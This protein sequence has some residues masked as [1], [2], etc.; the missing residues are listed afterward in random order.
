M[1]SEGLRTSHV[2]FGEVRKT[3]LN[4]DPSLQQDV[5]QKRHHAPPPNDAM[6]IVSSDD[7]QESIRFQKS[8]SRAQNS[9]SSPSPRPNR[10]TN[11]PHA[12]TSRNLYSHPANRYS[13]PPVQTS[14]PSFRKGKYFN[15][16]RARRHA[17]GIKASSVRKERSQMNARDKDKDQALVSTPS[18]NKAS[19]DWFLIKLLSS[20]SHCNIMSEFSP[21]PSETRAIAFD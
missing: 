4:I 7:N 11:F 18:V 19:L 13:S 15:P 9:S 6:I 8:K 20:R 5:Q 1:I 2:R 10:T 16:G 21:L 14:S 17:E 3:Q 12:G